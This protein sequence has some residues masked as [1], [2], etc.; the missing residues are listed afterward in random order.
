MM[1]RLLLL[2]ALASFA[3][4]LGAGAAQPIALR[5]NTAGELAENCGASPGAPGSDAKINFCIGFA[6]GAVDVEMHYAGD[7][8]PFCIPKPAPSRHATMVEFAS[9]V[10]AIPDRRTQAAAPA[11]FKFL[12]ERFPCK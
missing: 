8:K 10:K 4:L 9:W 7:K 6:Q 12:G 1:K 3:P 5:A 11:L 2:S